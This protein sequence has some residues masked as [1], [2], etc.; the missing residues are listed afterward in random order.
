MF[1]GLRYRALGL[2]LKVE[3][4]GLKRLSK[5]LALKTVNHNIKDWELI[6]KSPYGPIQHYLP[7]CTKTLKPVTSILMFHVYKNTKPPKSNYLRQNK[8]SKPLEIKF[9]QPHLTATLAGRYPARCPRPP[10]SSSQIGF[11]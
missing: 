3:G 4:L 9:R 2:R 7:L 10:A 6:M 5:M 8:N 1:R 11:M